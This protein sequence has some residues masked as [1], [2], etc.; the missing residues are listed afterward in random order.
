HAAGRTPRRKR[1]PRRLRRTGPRIHPPSRRSPR[2]Y[3]ADT[4]P[5]PADDRR[6]DGGDDA[7]RPLRQWLLGADLLAR[8]IAVATPLA[9]RCRIEKNH[10][11][12][13]RARPVV[14]RLLL[15]QQRL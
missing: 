11:G 6:T 14:L 9:G 2:P 3:A 8:S 12:M 7:R 10:R 4:P 13:L 15:R 1:Y 5:I